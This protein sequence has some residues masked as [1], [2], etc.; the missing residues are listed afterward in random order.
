MLF[1]C[2]DD[3]PEPH[4]GRKQEILKKHPEIKNL[5]GPCPYTKYQV[6][7]VVSMQVRHTSDE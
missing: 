4:I 7:G 6:A 3:G 2:R 5:M 1:T